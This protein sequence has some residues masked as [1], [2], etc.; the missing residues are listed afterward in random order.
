MNGSPPSTTIDN[1]VT[2]VSAGDHLSWVCSGLSPSEPV[3]LVEASP[4]AA[5]DT[6]NNQFSYSDIGGANLSITASA[7]GVIDTSLTASGSFGSPP[8]TLDCPPTQAEA[9]LGAIG[10]TAVLVDIDTDAELSAVTLDYADQASPAAPQLSLAGGSDVSPGG[11]TLV[12]QNLSG[13]WW[14]AGAAGA[15]RGART[16]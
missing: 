3:A 16:P 9:N 12:P 4:L 13:S 15:E 7:Q 6:P 11:A 10:C 2:G 1:A 5:D 14:G 8:N